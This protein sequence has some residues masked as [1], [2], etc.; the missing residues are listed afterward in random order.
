M[1]LVTRRKLL[2]RFTINQLREIGRKYHIYLPSR[3]TKTGIIS[4]L[5]DLPISVIDE[6]YALVTRRIFH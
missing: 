2:N 1:F 4:L 5:I 3:T 6:E